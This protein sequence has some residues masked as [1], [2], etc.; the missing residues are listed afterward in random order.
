MKKLLTVV[1]T[2]AA[3]SAL[4]ACGGGSGSASSAAPAQTEAASETEAASD[5][6]APAEQGKKWVIATDTVFRPFEFTD[7]N[8]NFVGI[9]VDILAA[10][11]EDQGFE[12]ELNSLG[13]DRQTG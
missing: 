10:V 11:A 3:V 4:C 1:L 2:I 9:D 5:T 12:Y 13:W 6:K 7:A 8:G